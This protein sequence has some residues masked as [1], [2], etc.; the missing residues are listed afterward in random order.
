MLEFLMI[1]AITFDLD[2]V[3]FINGKTNF[4]SNL[5][6]LGVTEE[7]AKRVFLQSDQM[8]K[9]YKEGKMT[10]QEFWSWAAKEWKLDKTPNELMKLLIDGYEVDNNVVA[11]VMKVKEKGYKT[12]ICSNNF[13]AR[14]NG[15]QERFKFL[16]NFDAWALS[17]EVE[18][19]KPS[20]KIFQELINKSVVK[21]EEIVFADDN[22]DNLEG[23]KQVGIQTF[24]YEGFDKFLEKLQD[25]GVDLK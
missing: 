20:T 18:A 16:D 22:N 21:P 17:Y 2:G 6:K 14:I 8:N 4:I 10:D 7:E 11:V 23:A 24:L 3:Y 19:T 15:L 25:L 1:K 5:Q 9:L 13:P 12:L